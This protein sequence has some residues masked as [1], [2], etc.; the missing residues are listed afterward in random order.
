MQCYVY[1][2]SNKE[3]HFL[4]LP[5]EFDQNAPS[6]ALPQALLE[7]LGELAL[8]V[9][10]D[11]DEDRKLPNANAHDVLVALNESGYYIQMPRETMFSSEEIYF[12]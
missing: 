12:N 7:L 11:L 10:F 9:N 1:K 8:V 6:E 5:K 2:G 4:Y 3:D